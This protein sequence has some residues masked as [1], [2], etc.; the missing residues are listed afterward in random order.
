MWYYMLRCFPAF[1]PNYKIVQILF[2]EKNSD[3]GKKR[4]VTRNKH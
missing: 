3:T 2:Q 4:K 1:F